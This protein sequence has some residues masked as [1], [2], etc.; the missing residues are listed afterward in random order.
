MLLTYLLPFWRPKDEGFKR[1]MWRETQAPKIVFSH[2]TRSQGPFPG[3]EQGKALGTRL[4]SHPSIKWTPAW[5]PNI[6]FHIYCKIYVSSADTS[7]K[8]TRTTIYLGYWLSVKSRWL[9]IGKVLFCVF[10]DWDGV[11]VHKQERGQYPAILTE[12]TWSINDIL[13]AFRGIFLSGYDG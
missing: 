11:E 1:E 3:L 2:Q 12:Q 9:D 10:V 13:Y 4:F 5:I 6:F 7:V 8:R